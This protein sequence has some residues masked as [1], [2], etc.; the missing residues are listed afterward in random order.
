MIVPG[1]F[2]RGLVCICAK[3]L[4]NT[5]TGS[6]SLRDNL[7]AKSISA[8]I[9]S[10]CWQIAKKFFRVQII[11]EVRVAYNMVKQPDVNKR[12]DGR[13]CAHMF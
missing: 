9:L 10:P 13:F 1:L 12:I 6:P 8:D 7:N 5:V 4:W 2:L 11:T 3:L